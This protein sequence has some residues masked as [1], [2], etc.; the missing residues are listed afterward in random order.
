MT[1]KHFPGYY[2]LSFNSNILLA[3]DYFQNDGKTLDP[4]ANELN[5]QRQVVK[6]L[7]ALSYKITKFMKLGVVAYVNLE[8]T[9]RQFWYIYLSEMD[10]PPN[11]DFSSF[12]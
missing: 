9:I 10:L 8:K 3:D 2:D 11:Y 1:D 12:D 6:V 7:G 5:A 4:T